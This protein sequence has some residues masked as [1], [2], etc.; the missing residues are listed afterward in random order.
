MV[1]MGSITKD[2]NGQNG[3]L[4]STL[5]RAVED[6]WSQAGR[7]GSDIKAVQDIAMTF[8]AGGIVD[9]HKYVVSISHSK[10]C[11]SFDIN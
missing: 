5:R 6:I 7:V 2:V 11:E 9:D 4:M 3:D 8:L 10:T 1:V